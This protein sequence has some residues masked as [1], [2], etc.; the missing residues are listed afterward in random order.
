MQRLASQEEDCAREILETVP[1]VMRMIRKELRKRGARVLSVPQFRTLAFVNRKKGASLSEAA[2]HIGLTLPTM[3]A[4]VDG[5]VTRG[6]VTRKTHPDDRRR[7]NLVLTDRG[8]TTLRVAREGT[9]TEFSQRLKRLPQNERSEV[10]RA[11]R[12]LRELFPEEGTQ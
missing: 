1:V 7:M 2:E 4:L 10:I 12:T 8:E 6:Y 9:L 5:L 11:M 3:S